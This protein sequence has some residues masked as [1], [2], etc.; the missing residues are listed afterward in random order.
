MV[1]TPAAFTRVDALGVAREQSRGF[2]RVALTTLSYWLAARAALWMAIEPGYAA[3]V[4]PAAGFALCA[5][6]LWGKHTALGVLVGSAACSSW[7]VRRIRS[8]FGSS[9]SR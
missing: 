3:P 6:L 7:Q 2:S 9:W 4:W 8:H 5:V 1:G